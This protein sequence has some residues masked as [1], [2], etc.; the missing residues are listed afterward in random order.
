MFILGFIYRDLDVLSTQCIDQNGSEEHMV[1]CD[2]F[3]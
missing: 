1:N 2:D 3:Q